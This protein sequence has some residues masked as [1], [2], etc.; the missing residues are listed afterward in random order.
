MFLTSKKFLA[1]STTILLSLVGVGAI[2]A[3]A[4]AADCP[5]PVPAGEQKLNDNPKANLR[6]ISPV[7]TEDNSIHRDELERQ[8]SIDCNWF[9]VGVRFN[10]VYVPYGPATT[11]TFHASTPTGAPLV[12]TKVTL[13]ANK[14]HSGSNAPV[15]IN[16][17][18]VR[19]A[20]EESD[21]Q[22]IDAYTDANGNVS[23]VV[24]PLDSDCSLYGGTLPAAP[25][26]P[27]AMTPNDQYKD[28]TVDC[29]VQMLPSIYGEKLDSADFVEFHYFDGSA[30]NNTTNLATLNLLSPTLTEANSVRVENTVR[31]YAPI[32]SKQY[33][34]FQATKADGTWARNQPVKVKINLANSG[35]NA[36]ITA[37][38][39][40]NASSGLSTTQTTADA[41]KTTEDQLVLSG[42]TDQFGQ[43]TFVLTNTDTAGEAPPATPTSAVPSSGAKFATITAEIT[44]VTSEASIYEYHFYKPAPPTTITIT[45]AGRKITVTINNAVGKTSTVAITGKAKVTL[46]PTVAKKVLTYTVTA[47]AKT[48]TV[49]ANGKT[50]TKKFTIR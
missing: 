2:S 44:G 1:F 6:L 40:G 11:L 31:T 21:G 12:N 33:L 48:I 36:K 7:L 3:P 5:W 4:H 16:G 22:N 34:S 14:S 20:Q 10:Q 39:F 49:T 41:T 47:G 19:P 50:L 45:A 25:A 9:G 30:L 35:A 8:F 27:L 37:G 26:N 38:I 15:R 13:R 46:K 32:G 23:F 29:Y 28:P 17:M 42:T 18:R 43:I 24:I